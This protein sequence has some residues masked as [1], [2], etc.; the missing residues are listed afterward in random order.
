M[1]ENSP[2]KKRSTTMYSM[3][4][5]RKVMKCV[6][7]KFQG[8]RVGTSYYYATMTTLCVSQTAGYTQQRNRRWISDS[9]GWTSS[10]LC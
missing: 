1:K 9:C 8:V 10:V 6:K 7:E 2:G 5:E 4:N 3:Q